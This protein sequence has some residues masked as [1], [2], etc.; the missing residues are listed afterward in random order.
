M[1]E[2]F[3]PTFWVANGMELFERLAYYGQATVLSIFLRDHLK[4]SEV[5]AG[6]LSSIFGGLLW[7]FPILAGTL[8]DKYGFKRAFTVAFSGLAI[9]YFLIGSTGMPAFAGVYEGMPLFGV[10]TVILIFTAM[11]GAFIKPAVLGTI[12]VTTKH[13]VRSLG[14][15]LY[16]WLVNIGGATG[17]V[18]AFLIR[19]TFG[20]GISFVYVVS[21]ISCTL[22]LFVNLIFY[23]NADGAAE[24]TESL[25]KKMQNL[26]VVL[27][28]F[29]FIIFLL[30]FSLYWIMFWQIFIIVPFY[31]TDY[32]SKDAPFELIQSADAWGIIVLQL[33]INRLTKN[34]SPQ[35]AMVAGF[36]VSSLCWLVIALHPTVWTI[37]AGLFVFAIGETTQAPRYYEYIADIAP[38]GQQG[39]FQG[40]GFLP[41][42]IAWGV[43]G[44]FGGWLYQTFANEMHQP[45]LIWYALFGVGI[46]ATILM[47]LYNLIVHRKS[48]AS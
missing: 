34:L 25:G 7:L 39:L 8:A 33:I 23:K 10:L 31:V 20:F 1:R 29:K 26:V 41:I 22:M 16:Y 3:H 43:G 17:P 36:G 32:I 40:Y 46:A 5:E 47:F 15:A 18:I 30:I 12:A 28:N 6:Q 14:Y 27:G 9:G 24:V 11:G 48:T 37:V 35:T 21:A 19:D 13:N 42:A 2:G 44:T 4:F 45:G 38:K